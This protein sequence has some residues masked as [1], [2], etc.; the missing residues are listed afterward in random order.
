MDL[1]LPFCLFQSAPPRGG[2]PLALICAGTTKVS[3][4]APAWGATLG[5]TSSHTQ[6][7]FQSAPPRGGRQEL[8]IAACFSKVSIRAPAWGA[9]GQFFISARIRSFN[10]RPRV[11]GDG[12]GRNFRHD[13]GWFQSAPPRGGRPS[14]IVPSIYYLLFQSAPP[15][16]GRQFQYLPYQDNRFVSIRAPAWG[17]TRK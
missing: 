9:T 11:G 6:L 8:Q 16:G 17:A 10:P 1:H 7:W 5:S 13:R 14:F 12:E 15:R 4:R 3:I 2:R